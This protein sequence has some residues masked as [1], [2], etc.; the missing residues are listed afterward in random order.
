LRAAE[1][2]ERNSENWSHGEQI[3]IEKWAREILIIAEFVDGQH[4]DR[5]TKAVWRWR[6]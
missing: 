5:R 3:V 4:P 6:F 2:A 1:F